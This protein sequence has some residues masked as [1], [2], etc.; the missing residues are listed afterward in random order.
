MPSDVLARMK[1]KP[2]V[3]ASLDRPGSFAADARRAA[4]LGADIIEIRLDAVPPHDLP[5]GSVA[6][7]L[8]SVRRASRRP[9]LATCRHSKENGRWPSD[10]DALRRE[11]LLAAAASSDL[12]DVELSVP[13][14]ARRVVKAAHASG[15]AVILSFH[16]FQ[17]TP[18][19]AVFKRLEKTALRLKGDIFKVAAA[20]HTPEDTARLFSVLESRFP[21][22]RVCIPMSQRPRGSALRLEAAARG[23]VLIYARL[24]RGTAP[25]QPTVAQAVK[26]VKKRFKTR[27]R[28][29]IR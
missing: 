3:V 8:S 22:R 21:I 10:Q 11:V 17:R 1:L 9:V 2:L 4:A 19:K 25:G 12:V 23:S 26:F 29:A 28:T 13:A 16:D 18:A 15:A 5:L 24:G 20:V 14:T 6:P 7:L 27:V